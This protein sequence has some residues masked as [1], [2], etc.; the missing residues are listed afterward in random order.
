MPFGLQYSAT[1]PQTYVTAL[2][3]GVA[4]YQAAY[5]FDT[6]VS[7]ADFGAGLAITINSALFATGNFVHPSVAG[8]AL[9]APKV[10]QAVFNAL[11]A[12]NGQRAGPIRYLQHL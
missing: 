10:T 8:H 1:Y 3:Q 6:R 9:V 2:R 4:A 12:A 11:N 7:L 5:P